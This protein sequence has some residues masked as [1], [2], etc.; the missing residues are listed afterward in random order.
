[1][2]I[3][4]L[5]DMSLERL[6]VAAVFVLATLACSGPSGDATGP[7]SSGVQVAQESLPAAGA[8]YHGGAPHRFLGGS[9]ELPCGSHGGFTSAVAPPTTQ[10][11]TVTSDYF[12]TFEGQL[13]LMPPLVAATVT[14]P[15]SI[16]VRMV[17]QITL[18]GTQGATRT[19]DTEL[20]TFELGGSSA[21]AGVMA[22]ESPNLASTGRTTITALSGGQYRIQSFYDVWL[23]ISLDGGGTWHPAEGA[24]RMTLGPP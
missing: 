3:R 6:T 13:I 24:V 9:A 8:A 1:M 12:A 19:F 7:G 5:C 16:P 18:A 10:G 23:E 17:E 20:L 14:H 2:W 22:R 21:P 11:G 15:L 4:Q